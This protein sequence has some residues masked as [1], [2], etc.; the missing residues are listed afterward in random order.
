MALKVE[1]LK[2]VI[3]FFQVLLRQAVATAQ[4][5]DFLAQRMLIMAVLAAPVAVVVVITK[6]PADLALLDKVTM[7]ARAILGAS[8]TMAAV[9][10][11]QARLA[12]VIHLNLLAARELHRLFLA[13][14]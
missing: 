8:R 13:R 11:A 12:G 9:V 4:H 5:L 2:A 3:L 7:V 10:A 1:A 6:A 14:L